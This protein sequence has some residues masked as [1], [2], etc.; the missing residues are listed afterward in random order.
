MDWI[1]AHLVVN[2]FP[3]VLSVVASAA[4][5]LAALSDRQSAWRF[6][7][8]NGLLAGL[9][10]PVAYL[11]GTRAE[12]AAEEVWYAAHEAIEHHEHWGLYALIA[13][14]VAGLLA[15][16][17]LRSR[18]PRARWAFA[19]AIWVATGVAGV[20]ALHGGDIVHGSAALEGGAATRSAEPEDD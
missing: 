20:A 11:S 7:C 8:V 12:E 19:I 1:Y 5:L 15:I 18:G 14:G 16:V 6:A 4:A 10:A 13:L 2:H 9:A 17:A 3:I